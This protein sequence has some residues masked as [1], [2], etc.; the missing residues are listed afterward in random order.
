MNILTVLDPV[1]KIYEQREITDD[2]EKQLKTVTSGMDNIL[3]IGRWTLSMK[4]EP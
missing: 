2:V 4:R 1:N 3:E